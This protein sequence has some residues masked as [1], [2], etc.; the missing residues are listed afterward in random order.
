MW[1][2][3][4]WSKFTNV[5]A[6]FAAFVEIVEVCGKKGDIWQALEDN[7]GMGALIGDS[8]PQRGGVCGRACVGIKKMLSGAEDNMLDAGGGGGDIKR[9]NLK[10]R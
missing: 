2:Y 9:G 1:F 5:S 3:V 6:A 7:R 10:S 8:G 4:V